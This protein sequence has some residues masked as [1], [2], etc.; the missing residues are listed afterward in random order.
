MK[1]RRPNQRVRVTVPGKPITRS[2]APAQIDRYLDAMDWVK[3][4]NGPVPDPTDRRVPLT[5]IIAIIAMH[6]GRSPGEVLADVAD[7]KGLERWL[8]SRRTW[9][10]W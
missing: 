7:G 2:I 10:T 1:R 6:E 8:R 4:R 3:D 9:P 5:R